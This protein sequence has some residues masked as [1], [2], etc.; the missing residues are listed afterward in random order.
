[1]DLLLVEDAFISKY[2]L[3]RFMTERAG[4]VKAEQMSVDSLWVRRQALAHG[5]GRSPL[6]MPRH[7]WFPSYWEADWKRIGSA[8]CCIRELPHT[9]RAC[10]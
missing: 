8:T 3:D 7:L 2:Q 6:H 4:F 9:R 10:A 1:V 5:D